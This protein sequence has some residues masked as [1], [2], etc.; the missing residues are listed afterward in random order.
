M[1]VSRLFS[2]LLPLFLSTAPGFGQSIQGAWRP[3]LYTL[4][5]GTEKPVTGLIFFTSSDWTVLFFELDE[6]GSPQRG[7]GEGGTY[8]LEKDALEFVHFYHLSGG[9]TP[10][11][12]SVKSF[13]E[14]GREPCRVELGEATMTIHFPSGNRMSFRRSSK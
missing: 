13:T 10:L 7:S 14:A 8:T 1:R 5:D 12:M 2:V 4:K 11:T 9:T 6:K 3:E